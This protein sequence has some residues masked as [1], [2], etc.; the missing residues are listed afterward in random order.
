MTRDLKDYIMCSS[1]KVLCV[2][3]TVGSQVFYQILGF[4]TIILQGLKRAGDVK[5]CPFS[6]VIHMK[7]KDQTQSFQ[8]AFMPS[9]LEFLKISL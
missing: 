3:L 1:T 9:L 4:F 8:N 6:L 5:M 2:T 7:K